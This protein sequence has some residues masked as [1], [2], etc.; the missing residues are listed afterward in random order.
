MNYKILKSLLS[1][2]D[3][4]YYETLNPGWTIKTYDCLSLI[5]ENGSSTTYVVFEG[6]YTKTNMCRDCGSYYEVSIGN[7]LQKIPHDK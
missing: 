3:K 1:E 2:S 4:N 5:F 6:P 7:M